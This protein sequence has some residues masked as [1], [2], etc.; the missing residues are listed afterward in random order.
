MHPRIVAALRRLERERRTGVFR[1]SAETI[2]R[3]IR[4]EAGAIVGAFSSSVDER[5]GEMMV[6][7]G[8]ITNQQLADAS[9]LMRSGRR[10]GDAL[11]ELGIVPRDEIESC[12]R[13]Q[14]AEITSRIVNDPPKQLEFR[15]RGFGGNC[16]RVTDT[17]VP[18]ADAILEAA[19]HAPAPRDTLEA[20]L[21]GSMIPVLTSE[22]FAVLESLVLHSH[23]AF[24]LSRCDG[25]ADT[26]SILAQSPLSDEETARIL[27]GF[28]HAGLIEMRGGRVPG[29]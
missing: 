4:L 23:E 10:L 2:R 19:R 25:Q 21:E 6:R 8:R 15:D 1:T 5:L 7:R 12:V 29:H 16:G 3:E 24:V 18:I 9:I 26:R 11:V 28:E 14:L 22:A 27:L 13:L 17:P 20:I